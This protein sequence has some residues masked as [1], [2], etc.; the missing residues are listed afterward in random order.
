MRRY[1]DV[2]AR[3]GNTNCT[4]QRSIEEILPWMIGGG[5]GEIKVLMGNYI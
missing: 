5:G 2:G 1:F 4:T 3:G